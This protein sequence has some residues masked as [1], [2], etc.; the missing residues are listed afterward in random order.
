MEKSIKFLI[1]K[2]AILIFIFATS[3]SFGQTASV[4]LNNNSTGLN[5][6][7]IVSIPVVFNSSANVG[8]WQVVLYYNRDVLTYSSVTFN[9]AWTGFAPGVNSNFTLPANSPQ[10]PNQLATKVSWLNSGAGVACSNLTAFTINFVYNG[11]TT[12]V[13][14][15][16]KSTTTAQS[17]SYFSFLRNPT[18]ININTSWTNG[19]AA[20]NL[21]TITSVAGGGNWSAGASWDLGH[22]PNT[23]NGNVIINS[24]SALV[25]DED[26]NVNG[27]LT[28]N[29]GAAL[30]VNSGKTLGLTGN[31]LIKSDA[32]GTGSFINNGTYAGTATV[33]RYIS[34][35]TSATDGWRFVSSPVGNTAIGNFVPGGSDDFFRYNEVLNLWENYA[36]SSFGFT[37]G[38]GYM[39]A[40]SASATKSFTGTINDA[41][42]SFSNLT[43]T[44]NVVPDTM[45]WHLLGN[46][47]SSS[48]KWNDGN[49]ALSN[50]YPTAKVLNGGGSYTDLTAND[51]IPAM[52]GFL[53]QLI[54]GTNSITIPALAR[55]HS[56][57]NLLN[58]S[59]VIENLK[60]TASSIGNNTYA[61]SVVKTDA[62]ATNGFDADFDANFL[63]GLY[64]APQLYSNAGNRK[65]S[66]NVLP[67]INNNVVMVPVSFVAGSASDY[68]LTAD[69]INTFN[70]SSITLLDL[71]T[72][73]TQDLMSNPVYNFTASA[74]DNVNRFQLYFNSTVGIG[75]NN[76]TGSKIYSYGNDIYVNSTDAIKQVSIYNTIG[77][78]IYTVNN[79]QGSFKYSL[80]G[81][82]T[83]YYIVKVITDKNVNSEKVFVK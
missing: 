47:F 20:G 6:G 37:K 36:V 55:I 19:S 64:G 40:Y 53:V 5:P 15:I 8:T 81:N 48:I 63:S 38:M 74:S 1:K 3:L 27:D 61:E 39:A 69:G 68:K 16:N 34:A 52:Q 65:L 18:T 13:D 56:A 33:Q 72:N 10:Y 78:L 49:W 51:V 14:V 17:Q 29:S 58:K 76:Q 7:D 4:V 83:G 70:C 75:E 79:P 77:Q 59:S 82:S 12:N 66:T 32:T 30:T 71:K 67:V 23:S 11:G 21:A 62:S 9:L 25:V 2:T 28:I 44:F 45:G 22:K 31:F 26:V 43:K 57:A 60:L 42:V 41:D 46:P 80:N 24:A 73:T 35:Y 54:S 50:V